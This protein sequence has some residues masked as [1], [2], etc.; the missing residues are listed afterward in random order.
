MLLRHRK[1][2]KTATEHQNQF[3]HVG[4]KWWSANVNVNHQR[5]KHKQNQPINVIEQ[6]YNTI[7][8][9]YQ[10]NNY[11]PSNS[12]SNWNN[13]KEREGKTRIPGEKSGGARTKTN[14]KLINTLICEVFLK[15]VINPHNL[16]CQDR[17]SNSGHISG[18]G[19]RSPPH[20][21][22]SLFKHQT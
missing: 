2:L 11:W 17:D 6:E 12:Q 10:L 16:W 8:T 7:L 22:C 3:L 14:N 15:L 13:M 21:P 19:A 1:C 18:G 4:I 5:P 20:H 9:V